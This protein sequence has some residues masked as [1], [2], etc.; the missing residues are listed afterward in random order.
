MCCGKTQSSSCNIHY[1][2][3]QGAILSPTLYNIFTSDIPNAGECEFAT[4][5]D[6]TTIF[7]SGKLSEVVCGKLQS[8]LDYSF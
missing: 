7:I 2:M 3:P 4:F 6:A 1:G 8:Q 5:A